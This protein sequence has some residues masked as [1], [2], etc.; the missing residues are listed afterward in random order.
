MKKKKGG[1][2]GDV[3]GGRKEEI[4]MAAREERGRAG[5]N[6]DKDVRRERMRGIGILGS[7][8]WDD[9]DGIRR[10]D[11]VAKKIIR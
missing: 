1:A 11:R 10:E 6:E 4:G 5:G 7:E 2:N 3:S 9:R 8:G